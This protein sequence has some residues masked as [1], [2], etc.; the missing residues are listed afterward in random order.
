ME[1]TAT[2]PA[3]AAPAADAAPAAAQITYDDFMKVELRVATIKAA[4][5]IPKSSKLVKLT[6]DLGDQQRTIVAGIRKSYA[7]EQLVGRQVVV[8]A[9]LQPAKLMGVESQGMVL[10]ASQD[11][12]AVLLHPEHEVPPGTRVK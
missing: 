11:G 8:V 12:D 4:E 10:A 9:N 2:S 1:P 3:A 5:E 6:V 7:P